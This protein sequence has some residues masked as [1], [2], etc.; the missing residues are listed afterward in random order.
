ML[1]KVRG[2]PRCKGRK[3]Y[4]VRR[5]R[6]RCVVCRYEWRPD[7]LPLRLS[8]REWRRLLHYFLLGLSSNKLA[9]ETGLERGRV[10]RALE[11]TRKVMARDTA[12]T[13]RGTVEVDETYLGGQWKN[14]RRKAKRIKAKRGRGTT[15]TPVFGILC[16]KGQV[17]AQVVPDTKAPTLLALLEGQVV[18]GSTVCSDTWRSY[19]GIAYRGYVHRTVEHGEGEYANTQGNHINGLEGFWGYLK[20]QLAAKGGIRRERLP[21]Y[22]AEYVWKYNHRKLSLKMRENRLLQ[23]LNYHAFNLN[24]SG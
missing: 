11:V 18:K 5:G 10:L 21:L 4:E 12:A 22:L 6:V 13:F 17:W 7:R 2:C 3:V 24:P 23:I 9:E 16:R 14:K 20:R 15:K 1:K 8:R 19:T